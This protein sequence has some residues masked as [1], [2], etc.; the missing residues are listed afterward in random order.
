MVQVPLDQS[1]EFKSVLCCVKEKFVSTSWSINPEPTPFICTRVLVSNWMYFTND[2]YKLNV[3]KKISHRGR[4]W[5]NRRPNDFRSDVKVPNWFQSDRKFFFWPFTLWTDVSSMNS[6][7]INEIILTYPFLRPV[8]LVHQWTHI[9]SY[10][11]VDL[12]YSTIQHVFCPCW[13]VNIQRRIFLCCFWSIWVPHTP[14][15][16]RSSSFIMNLKGQTW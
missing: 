10:Q 15:S 2:P 9:Q 3:S 6:R 14:R 1:N 13:Y 11:F 4:D 8:T 5:T 12:F 7:L 16:N